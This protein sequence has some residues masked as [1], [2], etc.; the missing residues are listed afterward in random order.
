MMNNGGRI[1]SVSP[2]VSPLVLSASASLVPFAVAKSPP[3]SEFGGE[4]MND[5]DVSL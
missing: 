4:A 5:I 3:M 2:P 1:K